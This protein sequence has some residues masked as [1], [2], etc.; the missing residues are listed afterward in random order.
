MSKNASGA[1]QLRQ[2]VVCLPPSLMFLRILVI[3]GGGGRWSIQIRQCASPYNVPSNASHSSSQ[4]PLC[5]AL[6]YPQSGHFQS[7]RCRGKGGALKALSPQRKEGGERCFIAKL[8]FTLPFRNNLSLISSIQP[9]H[10]ELYKPIVG[11]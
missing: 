5:L 8:N 11:N 1:I 6:Q 7:G 2:G 9:E 4:C 3:Q 10:P